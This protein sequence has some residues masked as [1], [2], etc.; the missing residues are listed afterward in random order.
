MP[1]G[2]KGASEGRYVVYLFSAD[3]SSVFLSLSQAVTGHRKRDLLSLAQQLR[4]EAGDQ[5]DL[6]STIDLEAQ[7]SLGEK[8]ALATAYAIRY[9]RGSVPSRED[10]ERDLSRFLE[11]LG[12]VSGTE[13]AGDD[14]GDTWLFQANPSKY[15]IDNALAE[16]DALTWVVR[17]Y[18]GEVAPGDR[19]YLW[20]S[21]KEAGVVAVA[22]VA[23]G[24]AALPFN[25]DDHFWLDSDGFN[26]SEPRVVLHVDAV[27]DT[28]L[29]RRDL[30]QHPLLKDL[31]VI[32]FANATNFRVSAQED[33][34]L[35]EAIEAP[36][37]IGAAMSSTFRG[38]EPILTRV[39]DEVFLPVEWL[40]EAVDLLS[41][42]RQVVFYGPPGTGKEDVPLAVEFRWRPGDGS[43]HTS[44]R[45]TS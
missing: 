3:G 29:L 44:V 23:E 38:L 20:R 43:S 30:L 17:Q 41:E 2:L 42:K 1:P 37:G 36:G 26:E 32:K 33:A 40:Q 21:G 8:Y 39:A 27:L 19:V 28:P 31:Q 7:G 45:S 16:L 13:T 9:E 14:L 34:A 12:S 35:R 15:D 18:T 24:P 22:T 4:T 10:L 25:E 6:L 11:I 5:P